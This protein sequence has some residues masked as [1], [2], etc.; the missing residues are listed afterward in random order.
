ME[1]GS[2]TGSLFFELQLKTTCFPLVATRFPLPAGAG[3][4]AGDARVPAGSGTQEA[5]SGQPVVFC[6][7]LFSRTAATT[8][9][10]LMKLSPT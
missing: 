4:S 2:P 7:V 3:A 9:F 8:I 1:K 10:L 6:F 5:I